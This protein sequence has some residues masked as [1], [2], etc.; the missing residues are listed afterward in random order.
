MLAP[1]L[2]LIL[3]VS[4]AYGIEASVGMSNSVTNSAVTLKMSV[5]QDGNAAGSIPM[6]N[7]VALPTIT[8]SGDFDPTYSVEANGKHAEVYAS[9]QNAAS[10]TWSAELTHDGTTNTYGLPASDTSETYSA[11][12]A[13]SA[14]QWLDVTNANAIHTHAAAYTSYNQPSGNRLPVASVSLDITDP[15]GKQASVSGLD[16]Y[17]SV[18]DIGPGI[19]AAYSWQSGTVGGLDIVREAKSDYTTNL[20]HDLKMDVQGATTSFDIYDTAYV[21]SVDDTTVR[22]SLKNQP[23]S[24]ATVTRA[25]LSDHRITAERGERRVTSI[26][27]NDGILP[28]ALPV[29]VAVSSKTGLILNDMIASPLVGDGDEIQVENLGYQYPE[30]IYIDKSIDITGVGTP[31]INGKA[32]DSVFT[33]ATGRA[34][35][36]NNLEIVNGKAS[37]GGGIKNY[38][39][40][41]ASSCDIHDNIATVEGGA[42]YNRGGLTL[43]GVE[44]YNNYAGTVGLQTSA[45]LGG[46]IYNNAGTASLTIYGGRIH[47]NYAYTGGAIYNNGGSVNLVDSYTYGVSF[48]DS[49]HAITSGTSST[50]GKGGAIYNKGTLTTGN[51]HIENNEARVGGGIY[52]DATGTLNVFGGT[53]SGNN[54]GSGG[55]ICNYG[56]ANVNGATIA[57]NHAT[58]A[59][60]NGGGI[61]NLGVLHVDNSEIVGNYADCGAGIYTAASSEGSYIRNSVVSSNGIYGTRTAIEGGGI[62]NHATSKIEISG[63]Q[64]QENSAR[65]G[66]GICNYGK[67]DLTNNYINLNH[68]YFT[69]GITNAGTGA[70]IY[71]FK[72]TKVVGSLAQLNLLGN[73]QIIGGIA[74][75]Y[76]G[77][78]YNS[79][80]AA[81]VTVSGPLN[82]VTGNTATVNGGG[83]YNVAGGIVPPNGPSL[84]VYGNNP[85]DRVG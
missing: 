47:D 12:S 14:E 84:T 81:R 17:A 44:M 51:A 65:R 68:A 41:T 10:Y 8:G 79:N 4:G 82:T 72:D 25:E 63:S 42:I 26:H 49:N 62:V 73:N 15:I 67:A 64:I 55:G 32:L 23:G 66:A 69:T 21:D 5:P 38:G 13:L 50:G 74:D 16:Q 46:A 6:L 80:G 61:A 20:I 57:N 71:N 3:L 43:Q 31:V 77:G 30:N 9:I 28:V 1:M 35:N 22:S 76:G 78:I 29:G 52:N 18:S 70:G 24:S 27:T 39:T 40:L 11:A 58:A 53:V 37:R 54:A 19:S 7:G 59:Q 33:I 36:L 60:S 56:T 75:K 45:N 2:A 34:V 48:I 83:I 85:N